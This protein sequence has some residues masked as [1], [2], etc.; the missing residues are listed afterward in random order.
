MDFGFSPKEEA[1]RQ[2]V[3]Q[4]LEKEIPPDWLKTGVIPEVQIDT[5]EEWEFA[6]AMARKYAERGWIGWSWPEQYGGRAGTK[7][8]HAII[9]EE[10]I[11]HSA[12][13]FSLGH[14]G[15]IGPTMLEF[16]TEA[17]KGL[18][19]TR[20]ARA[21]MWWCNGLSEPDAGSDLANISTTARAEGDHYI[22]NGHK[23]WGTGGRFGE[24][25]FFLA[26]TD[27]NS[28]RHRGISM[29][30]ADIATPGI[31]RKEILDLTGHPFWIETHFDN[32][33][34]PRENLIG[35]ENNGWNAA[36]T[37]LNNERS[38]IEQATSARRNLG[39]I[40]S[41][42]RQTGDGGKA[43]IDDP[44][45]RNKLADLAIRVNVSRLLCYR[46][47]WMREQ[48][49]TPTYET[50]VNKVV[51]SETFMLVADVAMQ[52]MGLYGQLKQGSRWTPL[53]RAMGRAYL[54]NRA[55]RL[56]TGSNEIQRNIIAAVGLGMPRQPS[57]SS[58]GG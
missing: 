42:A 10:M 12:P 4:F 17:Q 29:L 41:Y 40:I 52:V 48:D 51:A 30:I 49:I 33:R 38:V 14:Y 2:E 45:I 43:P 55:W 26:R 22:V 53:A 15:H 9:V 25:I 36:M 13:G 1:L 20:M 28:T 54:T 5:E 44:V 16:G 46:V 24:W 47:I 7:L 21:E 11:Y 3:R 6:K 27:P 23:C 8:E 56:G 39:Y 31:T 57:P 19:L 18:F 32:V 35:E 50:S 34:V 37:C 58:K